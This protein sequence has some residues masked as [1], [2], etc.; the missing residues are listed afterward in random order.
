MC[1]DTLDHSI[2]PMEALF[3]S[4]ILPEFQKVERGSIFAPFRVRI[5]PNMAEVLELR[6]LVDGYIKESCTVL[7][8]TY[9]SFI[10]RK[11]EVVEI[12]FPGR[13]GAS[14]V[15]VFSFHCDLS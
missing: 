10:R 7:P 1:E 13:T 9:E 6:D 15:V 5:G 4:K 11:I 8:R 14:L 3:K 12:V 2:S